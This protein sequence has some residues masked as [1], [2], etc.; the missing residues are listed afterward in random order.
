M[1]RHR[2]TRSD[3]GLRVQQGAASLLAEIT[4]LLAVARWVQPASVS[5]R[6]A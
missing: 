1:N 2:I 4:R 3:T 5:S 6:E